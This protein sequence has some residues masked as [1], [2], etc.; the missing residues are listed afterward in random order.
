M[1]TII[2]A[3]LIIKKII[4]ILIDIKNYD[5][6]LGLQATPLLWLIS[7]KCSHLSN[8]LCKTSD[9]VGERISLSQSICHADRHSVG[10]MVSESVSQ[11]ESISPS[12]SQSESVNQCTTISTYLLSVR[13]SPKSAIFLFLIQCLMSGWATCITVS[14]CWVSICMH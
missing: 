1:I 4:V 11:S 9:W 2:L 6:S 8:N 13:Q 10:Q 3:I 7:I 14:A 12:V 5:H